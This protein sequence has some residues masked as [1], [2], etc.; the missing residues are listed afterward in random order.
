MRIH[1]RWPLALC[2]VLLLGC[3]LLGRD[4]EVPVRQ[5]AVP[6]GRY[7]DIVWL[8]NNWLIVRYEPPRNRSSQRWNPQLYRLRPDGSAFAQL[9]LPQ[10]PACRLTR[11]DDPVALADGRVGMEQL[12]L[13]DTRIGW[14]P[15]TTVSYFL[16]YDLAT[17][18]LAPLVT[19]PLHGGLFGGGIA[20]PHG[21]GRMTWNPMLDRGV[22]QRGDGTCGSIAW[23]TSSGLELPAIKI[24]EGRQS[25][26]LDAYFQPDGAT[27]CVQ[28]GRV[29]A[30]AWSPDGAM[31]AFW[32][33]PQAIGVDGIARASVPGNIYLL[34]PVPVGQQP[35]KV[36]E[37]VRFGYSLTWSPDS[38]W[39][40]FTGE[41]PWRGTGLWLFA[42]GTAALQRV[43]GLEDITAVAWSPDGQKLV[44]THTPWQDGEPLQESEL[45][46][47]DVSALVAAP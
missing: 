19:V 3:S 4:P 44:A 34:D 30:P 27:E 43:T 10:D 23:I 17:S 47:F 24:Q 29:T 26:R 36:L 42:P 14:P 45:L 15:P 11:Y 39:L 40:A 2:A 7:T 46:L 18:R 38:R 1:R 20:G 28:Q 5:V 8:P 41:M 22:V 32:A 21:F 16:A 12:C 9:P 31:I 33:S 6:A 37:K 25:W 35:R 13:D